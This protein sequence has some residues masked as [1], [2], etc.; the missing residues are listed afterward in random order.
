MIHDVYQRCYERQAAFYR[1]RPRAKKLLVLGNYALTAA[2]F[3]AYALL[4][5]TELLIRRAAATRADV[6]RIV[7]VPLLCLAAVSVLRSL[8]DRKRPYETDGIR[9]V[10]VKKKKGHSFPS[11]HV[12]SA[13]VIGMTLL[14][15][16]RWAGIV[17]FVEGAL[18]GYIRFAAGIHYPSD[19]LAGAGIG[20]L[21]GLLAFI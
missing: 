17:V 1:T 4:C 12:A 19:L 16:C 10:I 18:L 13:F 9:P 20:V 11:R 3:L 21:F 6:V 14:F 5:L 2:V 15:Y 7:A 8:I